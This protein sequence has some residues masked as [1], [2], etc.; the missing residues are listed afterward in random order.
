MTS[1]IK[2]EARFGLSGPGYL[3]APVF[4]AAIGHFEPSS[5]AGTKTFHG[6]LRHE[7]PIL[8]GISAPVRNIFKIEFLSTEVV[9]AKDEFGV[10]P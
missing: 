2:T 3:L 8:M 5:A 4:E 7:F 9:S 6:Y 10:H 1:E